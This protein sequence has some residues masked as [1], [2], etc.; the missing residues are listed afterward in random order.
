MVFIQR[1]S[2]GGGGPKAGFSCMSTLVVAS[3]PYN[4]PCDLR[5]LNFT[6]PSI[7]KQALGDTTLYIYN[8]NISVC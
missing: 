5:P 3:N 8:I 7:L 6:I 4:D 2:F 1:W